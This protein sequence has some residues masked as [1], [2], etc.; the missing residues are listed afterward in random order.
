MEALYTAQYV[1]FLRD[2][3]GRNDPG[4]EYDASEMYKLEREL[5]M[6]VTQKNDDD[7]SYEDLTLEEFQAA[8]DSVTVT[9]SE[10]QVSSIGLLTRFNRF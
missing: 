8:M 10:K 7:E 1:Q 6:A 3:D 5:A 2:A 9:S 4:H